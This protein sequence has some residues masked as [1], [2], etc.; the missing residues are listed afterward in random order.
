MVEQEPML[1]VIDNNSS[2][3]RGLKKLFKSVGIR[4]ET[5]SSPLEFL[6]RERFDGP[7]CILL[8]IRIPEMSGLDLQKILK[9]ANYDIPIIFITR[10]ADI[11]SCVRAMK[12]GAEDFM[13]KPF[14]HQMLLDAVNRAI[15]KARRSVHRKSDDSEI[16]RRIE[17]LT[18]REYEIFTRMIQG[19]SIRQMAHETGTVEGTIK[20]HRGKVLKKMQVDSVV[21]LIKMTEKIVFSEKLSAIHPAIVAK[22]QT[23]SSH[24]TP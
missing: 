20:A 15:G 9:R 3:Q 12:A 10:H 14:N 7:S 4:T 13:E 19:Q 18:R 24:Q 1:F 8:E 17:S 16:Q 22:F 21:A 2:V 23:E 11:Q 5:F 6:A